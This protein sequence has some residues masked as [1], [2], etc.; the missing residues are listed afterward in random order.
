MDNPAMKLFLLSRKDWSDGYYDEF[1]AC[2]VCALNEEDAKK[3]R[4]DGDEFREIEHGK[5]NYTGWVRNLDE[6]ECKE[7]GL[8]KHGQERGV[9]LASFNAG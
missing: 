3:I 6:I 1:K 4:P 5:I 8:T 7:I 2:V 9:V